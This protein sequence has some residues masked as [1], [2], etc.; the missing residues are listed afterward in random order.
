MGPPA[1]IL[2]T[3]QAVS[4]LVEGSVFWLASPPRAP[5]SFRLD[6][7]HVLYNRPGIAQHK[8]NYTLYLT[9][10]VCVSLSEGCGW[11]ICTIFPLY[12]EPAILPNLPPLKNGWH[13][14]SCTEKRKEQLLPAPFMD[15]SVLTYIFNRWS[16]LFL[17]KQPLSSVGSLEFTASKIWGGAW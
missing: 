10:E 3:F 12:C 4:D 11:R 17:D 2:G 7:V 9:L 13:P 15:P 5:S 8:L 16:L 1:E 6:E 14:P